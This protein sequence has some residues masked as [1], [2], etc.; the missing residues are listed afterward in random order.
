[1]AVS[2]KSGIDKLKRQLAAMP[3]EARK[4]IR[5]ALEK[6]AGNIVTTAK[7]FAPVADGDLRNSIGFT[8]GE[9]TAD[10]SNVRGV[11]AGGGALGG[12]KDLSVT[13]HAGDEVA[14]YASFVELGT[15]AHKAGGY[16]AGSGVTIPAGAAQPFF[17]PAYRANKKRV[18]SAVNRAIKK[19]AKEAV[20]Q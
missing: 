10:N 17:F 4:T 9:Y 16:F 7:S 18:Q 6:G 13:I 1:M 2:S 11:S 15:K 3:K 5:K 20:G 8:F 14:Y 19:A 12:D